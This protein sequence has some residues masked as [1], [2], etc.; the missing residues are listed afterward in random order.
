M[1]RTPRPP[2][3]VVVLVAAK[4]VS[5]TAEVAEA[6]APT[7]AVPIAAEVAVVASIEAEVVSLTAEVSKTDAPTVAVP[8]A[9]EVAVAASVPA[10]VVFLTAAWPSS[11][12]RPAFSL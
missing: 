11:A 4:V 3:E 12:V 6:D 1:R 10:K 2:A 5:L 9:A 8:I 7:V